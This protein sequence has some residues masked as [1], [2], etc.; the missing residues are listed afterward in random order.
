MAELCDGNLR[1]PLQNA[2]KL[3]EAAAPSAKLFGSLQNYLNPCQTIE[4]LATLFKPLQN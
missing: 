4:F 1:K 2:R 3:R